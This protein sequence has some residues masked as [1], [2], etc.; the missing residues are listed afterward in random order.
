VS[1]QLT[2]NEL[3][4]YQAGQLDGPARHRVERLLLE[5]PFYADALE[6]LEALQRTGASL[7][8]QTA[9]LR[10]ALHERINESATE[11]RLFPLW[12]TTMAASIALVMGVA[13]YFIYTT[14]PTTTALK[15]PTI[16]T[17]SEPIVVQIGPNDS[18]IA[19]TVETVAVLESHTARLRGENG[20]VERLRPV[21][22]QTAGIRWKAM[23]PVPTQCE[24]TMRP[25]RTQAEDTNE[26]LALTLNE[27]SVNYRRIIHPERAFGP[28]APEAPEVTF[29][30]DASPRLTNGIPLAPV[31]VVGYGTQSRRTL[32]GAV[33]AVKPDLA[34]RFLPTQTVA[35]K[36]VEGIVTD[37]KGDPLPGAQIT[38]KGTNRG[39]TTNAK[40]Q[41][42]FDSTLVAGRMLSVAYV[43]FMSQELNPLTLKEG[44]IQLAEDTQALNEVVVTGYGKTKSGGT[45]TAKGNRGKLPMLTRDIDLFM[46]VL[47]GPEKEAFKEYLK[48][49]A[50]PLFHGPLSVSIRTKADGSIKRVTVDDGILIE[51]RD[52]KRH[53]DY[54]PTPE[55]RA[56]AERLVRQYPNW[57]KK[58]QSFAWIMGWPK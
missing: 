35:L 44:P 38:V 34:P 52:G 16:S 45:R 51:E 2:I 43:G 26:Q 36:T 33:S 11:R 1:N 15:K 18:A 7:P 5:D 22:S 9:Q 58:R 30:S 25:V 3:R 27:P 47:N 20:M 4:A 23:R 8:K 48:K 24:E 50:S 17:P 42:S 39:T 14:K 29:W 10:R 13:L 54:K 21:S 40:G 31:T 49:E 6:G 19:K 55:V 46:S 56:E 41:F 28:N 57:P 12:I 53:R 37:Q 32:T